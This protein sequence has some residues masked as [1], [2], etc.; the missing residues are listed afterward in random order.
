MSTAT[1]ATSA[2]AERLR[3]IADV[4]DNLGALLRDDADS[5]I[6]QE[7]DDLL[8]P[9]EAARA[10]KLSPA[11]VRQQAAAGKLAAVRFGSAWRIRRS[12]LEAYERRRTTG[13]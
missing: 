5:A 6:D 3:R 12:A 2:R 7:P 10:L 13:R 9:A 8:T 11:F 1:V 4:L